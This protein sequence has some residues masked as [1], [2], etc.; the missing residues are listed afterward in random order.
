MCMPLLIFP[1]TVKFRSSLLAPTH[2]DGPGKRVV[3]RLWWWWWVVASKA[4]IQS[5]VSLPWILVDQ[6]STRPVGNF[7][8]WIQCFQV[9]LNAFTPLAGQQE[10]CTLYPHS[11][12]RKGFG[13]LANVVVWGS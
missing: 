13:K 3:K 12:D 7:A 4:S 1:C 8:G 9:L 11:Q 6:D 2:P 10:L 5:A